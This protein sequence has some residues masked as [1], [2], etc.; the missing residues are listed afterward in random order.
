[1]PELQAKLL[2]VLETGNHIRV[3]DTKQMKADV[4]L[5]AATQR[6]L[7]KEVDKGGFRQ[8]LHYR[9]IAHGWRRPRCHWNFKIHGR[10]RPSPANDLR[11]RSGGTPTGCWNLPG[12]INTRA[13]QLLRIG[14]TAFYA[15]VKW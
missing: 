4:R 1:M 9:L 15:K 12:G 3:V 8:D 7:L 6:G 10:P 13:A 14:L 11:T 2:R 5:N